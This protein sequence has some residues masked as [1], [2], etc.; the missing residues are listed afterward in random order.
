MSLWKIPLRNQQQTGVKAHRM[1]EPCKGE[2]R[3]FSFLIKISGICQQAL[4]FLPTF[5]IQEKKESP[6]GKRQH[7]AP[8]LRVLWLYL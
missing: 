6:S 5:F 2:F 1:F 4:I 7:L 8:I 3:Q